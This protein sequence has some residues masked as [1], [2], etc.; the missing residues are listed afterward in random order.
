MQQALQLQHFLQPAAGPS[1]AQEQLP[2][3]HTA[4]EEEPTDRGGRRYGE[5]H[6]QHHLHLTSVLFSAPDPPPPTPFHPTIS[7][8]PA[9]HPT[10]DLDIIHLVRQIIEGLLCDIFSDVS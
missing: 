10:Q 2:N 1:A 8:Q 3:G 4:E 5:G 9:N 7:T 6:G